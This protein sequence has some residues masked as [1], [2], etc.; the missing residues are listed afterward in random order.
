MS[1]KYLKVDSKRSLSTT[2]NLDPLFER[3]N[4]N[5]NEEFFT[6]CLLTQKMKNLQDTNILAL[7]PRNLLK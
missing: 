2:G 5:V 7:S 4:R 6:L 3:E 1:R